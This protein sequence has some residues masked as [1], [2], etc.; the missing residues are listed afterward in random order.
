[1]KENLKGWENAPDYEFKVLDLKVY[2]DRY[3][4]EGHASVFHAPDKIDDIVDPGAFK[5]TIDHHDGKFP[6]VEMH[7]KSKMVGNGFVHEDKKGLAV[8]PGT[9]IRGLPQ[10]ESAYLLL[11]HKVYDG[12]SFSYRAIQK[13]FRGKF[14]HLKEV[15]VGELTLAPRSMI[16][17][18]DALISNVKTLEAANI[19]D[20]HLDALKGIMG[21]DVWEDGIQSTAIKHNLR[22]ESDFSK[23]SAWWID[24]G[25][26]I[27]AFGGPLKDGGMI[28]I[29]SVKFDK[30]KGWEL[31]RAKEWARSDELK[32][33]EITAGTSFALST[34]EIKSGS[35]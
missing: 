24:S 10:A 1:M 30:S 7:D 29:Q 8:S 11:K 12:M 35:A 16:C 27:Q 18:P 21:L 14:R 9:L 25:K 22:K 6:I 23:L 34:H 5:R 4:F 33:H 26:T 19:L 31:S 20:D 17:H 15:A 13:Y 3:E 28:A 2:E 32:F